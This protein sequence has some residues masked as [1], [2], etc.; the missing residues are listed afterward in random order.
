MNESGLLLRVPSK[1]KR[2]LDEGLLG[3]ALQDAIS[4]LTVNDPD[5][6]NSFE[7]IPLPSEP[8]GYSMAY[9]EYKN[10][11]DSDE[12]SK[13]WKALLKNFPGYFKATFDAESKNESDFYFL[14]KMLIHFEN[15][16]LSSY[17]CKVREKMNDY[18]P[19]LTMVQKRT[20]G[21]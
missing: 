2:L 16:R 9:Q 6:W 13:L 20:L 14:Q 12:R 4:T 19:Y 11:K 15:S 17:A 18:L 7:P 3:E 21:I 8:H 10:E 5:T 1:F